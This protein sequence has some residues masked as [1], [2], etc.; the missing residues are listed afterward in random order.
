MGD[1]WA[2]VMY[3]SCWESCVGCDMGLPRVCVAPVAE[4]NGA[5]RGG[6]ALCMALEELF[7]C[8]GKNEQLRGDT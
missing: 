2:L 1:G 6:K 3:G 7:S 8:L 5:N 4:L